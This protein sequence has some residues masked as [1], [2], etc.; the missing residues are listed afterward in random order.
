MATMTQSVSDEASQKSMLFSRRVTKVS[1]AKNTIEPWAKL[2]TPDALKT[3][4]KPIA[5]SEYIT[6]A[7]Q[8][9]DQGFEKEVQ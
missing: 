3:S 1:A 5:T 7:K 6:P 9:A 8:A 2:K 4:T